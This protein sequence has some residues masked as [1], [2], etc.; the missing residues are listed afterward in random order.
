MVKPAGPQREFIQVN[1][2]TLRLPPGRVGGADPGK[3][4]RQISQYGKR[5]DGLPP[6]SWFAGR[7]GSYSSSTV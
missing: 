6:R 7:T 4:A 2:R 3:L 5:I 1:P